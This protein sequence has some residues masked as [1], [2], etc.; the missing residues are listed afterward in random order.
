MTKVSAGTALRLHVVKTRFV[1]GERS[2]PKSPD[3]NLQDQITEIR[4]MLRTDLSIEEIATRC[5]VTRAA[6]SAFIKRRR[7]CNMRERARFNGL[8]KTMGRP[9]CLP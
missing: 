8:Q 2:G 4:R 6:L 1:A 3:I 5:G 7:L 9:A